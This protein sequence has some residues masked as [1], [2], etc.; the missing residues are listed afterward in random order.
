MSDTQIREVHQSE[1]GR[2]GGHA[3]AR[4]VG[5]PRSRVFWSSLSVGPRAAV[6]CGCGGWERR[7][8]MRAIAPGSQADKSSYA[9]RQAGGEGQ[10][11]EKG[12]SG[13]GPHREGSTQP[14]APALYLAPFIHITP[15]LVSSC[16]FQK[17]LMLP[18][19]VTRWLSPNQPKPRTP[20]LGRNH[21]SSP[22]QATA[23]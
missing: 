12:C 9:H 17:H 18:A 15:S 7:A 21:P 11:Q 22:V 13:P 4:R 1:G 6:P 19:P 23:N 2:Q 20:G 5:Q 14:P 10:T 16:N 8:Q 3:P